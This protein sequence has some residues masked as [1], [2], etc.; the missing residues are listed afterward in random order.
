MG[1]IRPATADKFADGWRDREVPHLRTD[2]C[3]EE[4]YL[5]VAV[6]GPTVGR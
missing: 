1:T 2:V 5:R 3:I 6:D 4:R